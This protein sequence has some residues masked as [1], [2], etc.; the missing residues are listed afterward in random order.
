MAKSAG[1]SACV[2]LGMLLSIISCAKKPAPAN[3]TPELQNP[4]AQSA[5]APTN[6]D[7]G[8]TDVT[9]ISL[10]FRA[11]LGKPF[12]V[13]VSEGRYFSDKSAKTVHIQMGTN[14]GVTYKPEQFDL[15]PLQRQLVTAVVKSSRSGLASIEAYPANQESCQTVI[16]V[17]F[18]G[19][20]KVTALPLG[21]KEPQVLHVV[22]VDNNDKPLPMETSLTMQLQSADALLH[23]PG[24]SVSEVD[25][26][27]PLHVTVPLGA[28]SSTPFIIESLNRD[29]GIVHL[30]ATLS[31]K[32]DTGVIS[33]SIFPL[34]SEPVWWLPVVLAIG[35]AVMYGLYHGVQDKNLT[36]HWWT[37]IPVKLIISVTAGII[38]YLFADYDLLGLKLDPHVLRTY[39]LLG[40]LFSFVGIDALLSKKFSRDEPAKPEANAAPKPQTEPPGN[41]S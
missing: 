32:E 15:R 28:T 39:P 20:L 13:T 7:T 4:A 27:S 24:A 17:G 26:Y 36:G 21:Y 35:G 9:G 29:G 19:H 5:P 31:I 38:A 16:D 6:D 41:P 34:E 37:I 1:M 14:E 2:A 33:Q 25:K 8:D 3:P 22:V 40:F 23:M 12:I 10:P 18:Q 11:E 30:L